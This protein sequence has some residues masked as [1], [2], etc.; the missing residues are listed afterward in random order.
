MKRAQMHTATQIEYL[1]RLK[2]IC[3][4]RASEQANVVYIC[5]YFVACFIHWWLLISVAIVIG[6]AVRIYVNTIH[7]TL[8][9]VRTQCDFCKCLCDATP[10]MTHNLLLFFASI[11]LCP[12]RAHTHTPALLCTSSKITKW[13][14]WKI[15]I[16]Y[17][18]L[19]VALVHIQV[20]AC[21]FS[22]FC[23]YVCIY[24]DFQIRHHFT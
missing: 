10:K 3:C 23:V 8:L 14:Q 19:L 6:Y 17:V 21:A 20:C 22:T 12:T 1:N 7:F 5:F 24:L 2:S 11:Y 13:K 9:D 15:V 16:K 4:V 18:T